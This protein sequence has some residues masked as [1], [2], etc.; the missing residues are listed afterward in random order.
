MTRISGVAGD[1]SLPLR[2]CVT[3]LDVHSFFRNYLVNCKIVE[4]NIYDMKLAFR[5]SFS[6]KYPKRTFGIRVKSPK[7]LSELIIDQLTHK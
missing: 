3:F 6:V 2:A 7:F 4:K 1:S 5:F